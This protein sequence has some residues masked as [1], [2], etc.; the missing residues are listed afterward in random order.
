ME[1]KQLDRNMS[2]NE[3]ASAVGFDNADRYLQ[4]LKEKFEIIDRQESKCK[5][6]G[7]SQYMELSVVEINKRPCIKLSAVNLTKCLTGDTVTVRIPSFVDCIDTTSWLIPEIFDLDMISCL[8][9]IE[10]MSDNIKHIVIIGN[11]K[12]LY[13]QLDRAGVICLRDTPWT[14]QLHRSNFVD[15]QQLETLVFKDFDGRNIQQIFS[16]LQSRL[17]QLKYQNLDEIGLRKLEDVRDNKFSV[18]KSGVS[19]LEDV[20]LQGCNT[21][22]GIFS[23][24]NDE[25]LDLQRMNLRE[26][27]D[28]KE[29]F[30]RSPN[31][32]SVKFGNSIKYPKYSEGMDIEKIFLDCVK[33]EEIPEGFENIAIHNGLCAFSNCKSI[34][35][36]NQDRLDIQKARDLSEMFS[37]SGLRGKIVIDGLKFRNAEIVGEGDNK[38]CRLSNL[39]QIHE[40]FSSCSKITQL[41][42]KNIELPEVHQAS[43]LFDMC[44]G[45]KK[46]VIQNVTVGHFD[47]FNET[48]NSFWYKDGQTKDT[49]VDFYDTFQGCES[50]EEV[51]L[52][53]VRLPII[54]LDQAF[55]DCENLRK[56]RLVDSEI[57]GIQS[58]GS[59]FE[60]CESLSSIELINSKVQFGELFNYKKTLVEYARRYDGGCND[61]YWSETNT[62]LQRIIGHY[63]SD[64]NNCKMTF[65]RCLLKQIEV[66]PRNLKNF[67]A[68]LGIQKETIKPEEIS[69]AFNKLGI[70]VKVA[71]SENISHITYAIG[72]KSLELMRRYGSYEACNTKQNYL[73]LDLHLD[74]TSSSQQARIPQDYKLW[75][76]IDILQEVEKIQQNK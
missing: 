26:F 74:N 55:E 15:D 66:D 46:V 32:R 11:G 53:K 17:K 72:G 6:L 76:V 14:Q 39:F 2:Y 22:L 70:Y 8:R 20:D 25:T 57:F 9:M 62:D 38:R 37:E 51:E 23:E 34:K 30:A 13:G 44:D 60:D 5:L 7:T 36:I 31:L 47:N 56:I 35:K 4:K 54:Q 19:F 42:I 40:I 21:V 52:I 28:M 65:G 49:V 3:A 16:V 1:F 48:Y 61:D 69:E 75:K 68:S 50:L 29:L 10:S 45:L 71:D 18:L 73:D 41:E 27:S 58:S 12:P 59:M 33:L 43:S 63:Y 67:T 64:V 24:I